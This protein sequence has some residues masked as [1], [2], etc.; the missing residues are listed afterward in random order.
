MEE[1][2]RLARLG[3]APQPT[4]S[5][6]TGGTGRSTDD[7]QEVDR[8]QKE[9]LLVL[10]AKQLQEVGGRA[11]MQ[12]LRDWQRAG[13]GST[14]GLFCFWELGMLEAA[15]VQ[16]WMCDAGCPLVQHRVRCRLLHAPVGRQSRCRWFATKRA[17]LAGTWV[18]EDSRRRIGSATPSH[19]HHHARLSRTPCCCWPPAGAA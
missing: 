4:S 3:L 2:E 6:D 9:S 17:A 1:Q 14:A 12:R 8:R 11:G 16:L 5:A 18:C 7:E 13:A 15:L 19:V 10:K